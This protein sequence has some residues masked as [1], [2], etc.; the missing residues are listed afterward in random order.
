MC[1]RSYK[2]SRVAGAEELWGEWEE[3]RPKS[4]RGQ[5]V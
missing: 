2:E 5:I 4:S 3:I 1:L